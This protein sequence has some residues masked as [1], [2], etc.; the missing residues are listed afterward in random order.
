[1]MRRFNSGFQI[2]RKARSSD[3]QGGFSEVWTPQAEIDGRLQALSMREAPR[4]MQDKGVIA[5]RFT[6]AAGTD[7]RKGDQVRREG[8]TV[9]VDALSETSAG[10]FIVAICEEVTP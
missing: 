8:R 6:C 7:L 1:M 4:A 3:G 10:G 2:F 5:L 9:K